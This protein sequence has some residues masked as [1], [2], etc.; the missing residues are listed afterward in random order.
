MSI[1]YCEANNEFQYN[2]P[3]IINNDVCIIQKNLQHEKLII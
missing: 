2:F 1:Q 3:F